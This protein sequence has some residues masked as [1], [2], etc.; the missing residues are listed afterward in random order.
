RS[1]APV[2]L[3][4]LEARLL[5]ELRQAHVAE[6]AQLAREIAAGE[7]KALPHVAQD[8]LARH[9][10]ELDVAPSREEGEAGLHL[11]LELRARAAEQRA[12][13]AVEAEAPVL[14]AD[15]VEDAEDGLALCDAQPAPELLQE[16]RGALGGAEE[17]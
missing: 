13:A 15:E 11:P 2:Q 5:E 7:M 6:V 1:P 14:L 4:G 16:D 3:V 17:E 9:P 8:D 10:V 12:V